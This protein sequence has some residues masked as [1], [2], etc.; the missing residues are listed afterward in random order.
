MRCL[1][2]R[3]EEVTHIQLD[4]GVCACKPCTARQEAEAGRLLEAVC[5]LAWYSRGKQETL[6]LDKMEGKDQP[7]RFHSDSHT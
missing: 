3:W 6:S 1:L 4:M 5:Q 7:G 2:C